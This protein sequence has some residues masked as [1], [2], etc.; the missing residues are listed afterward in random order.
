M[1][2]KEVHLRK[3]EKTM[4]EPRIVE[5]VYDDPFTLAKVEQTLSFNG[6]TRM[7]TAHGFSKRNTCDQ[8]NKEIGKALAIKD[9]MMKLKAER[10]E[11]KRAYARY[12]NKRKK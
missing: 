12:C 1:Q 5:I 4:S 6:K 9:A 8:P 2:L 10:N 11:L 3:G 7:I